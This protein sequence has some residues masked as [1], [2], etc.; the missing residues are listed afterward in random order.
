MASA[1]LD[2]DNAQSIENE[3]SIAHFMFQSSN[4]D[5]ANT[6]SSPRTENADGRSFSPEVH[7]NME[8]SLRLEPLLPILPMSQTLQVLKMLVSVT[9]PPTFLYLQ[10]KMYRLLRMR[11]RHVSPLLLL[12]HPMPLMPT[13]QAFPGLTVLQ[14]VILAFGR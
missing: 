12:D 1:F 8:N 11:M 9:F 6:S 4:A 7:L 13:R 2:L 14:E 3:S 5:G 10:L